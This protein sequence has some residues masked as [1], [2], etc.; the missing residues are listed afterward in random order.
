MRIVSLLSSGTEILFAIGLGEQ[1][2]AV[3]H[4]C[5]YPAA[6]AALPKATRSLVDSSQASGQIDEQV[7]SLA[8][9]GAALY[10]LEGELI[11]SLRPEVIVTQA[12]CDVCAVRYADVVEL[13]ANSA[14]LAATRV[15]PLNPQSLDEALADVL[16]V[17]KA[18]AAAAAAREFVAGLVAR[19]GRVAMTLKNTR[20]R[21]VCIEWTDPLMA[22]GNW[23]PQL[24][25]LAGGQSGLAKAGQ[26]SGYVAWP[27]VVE[28]DPQVL[29]VAPCGFGLAR[30]LAEASILRELPGWGELA[31]VKAGR[32]HVIDGNAY[33]NRSGPRLVDSLEI[34][35]HLIHPEL[36]PPP[37]GELAEGAAWARLL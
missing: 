14:D 7:K 23:T 15:V 10:G 26:H 4:E 18:C 19:V 8:G 21:V 32:A 2:M 22:A 3:S 16:R 35:A 28:F 34:L 1:V 9:A 25:D 29:L 5:D 33:L 24:I 27:E 17:G 36:F 12:Q 11:R 37:T 20:P 13:V 31:A 30:S 6:A